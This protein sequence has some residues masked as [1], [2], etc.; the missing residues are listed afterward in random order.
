MKQD[1][2]REREVRVEVRIEDTVKGLLGFRGS[3]ERKDRSSVIYC[4]ESPK[5]LA[6]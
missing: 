3:V 6:N 1:P 5:R 4:G 2:F